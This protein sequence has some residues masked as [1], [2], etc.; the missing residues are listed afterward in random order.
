MNRLLLWGAMMGM[1]IGLSTGRGGEIEFV[2]QFALAPDRAAALKQLIPGT[3]DYYYWNSLHLLNT[4]QFE[5]V[6]ELLKPWV[7]RHGETPRVWEIRTRRAFLTYDQNPQAAL[8]YLRGRFGIQFPHRKEEL[9][10]EPNFPTTLDPAIVSRA[11]YQQ[12]ALARHGNSLNGF[13]DSA[14][15]WLIAT[16]LTPDQRRQLLSRLKRPDYPQLVELVAADLG[17]PNSGGFGS[18]EI[19]RLLLKSQLDE[20]LKLKPELLNQQ[21]FVRAYIVKLQHG[22]DVDWRYDPQLLKEYL[23]RLQAFADRLEPVHNS[24]KA[25]VLYHRLWLDRSRGVFDLN[26]LLAYLKLPRPTGYIAKVLQESEAFRQFP[27]DLNN[28]YD[29]VTLLPPIGNDEPL[30]RSYLAHFLLAGKPTKDFE[31]FINDVYLKHLFAETKIVNS[32]G[33]PEQWASLL[34]PDQFRRLKDRVDLDFDPANQ[35][36]FA[37]N[38][39]VRLDVHVK[40]VSTLIVKV[41]EINARNFYRIHAR[42]IDTDINLDGLVAND[43]QSHA[44][45]ESPFHRVTRHFEFPKLDRP[46][47]YVIDF[48]GNGQSSRALIRKGSLRH[49]VRTTAAGQAFTVLDDANAQV[50]NATLWTAGHEYAADDSGEILVPFSTNPSRQPVVL[51]AP[52]AGKPG[53]TYSALG[54]YQQEAETYQFNAGFYVDRESLLTRKTAELLI[55]PGLSVNGTPVSLKMLEDIKLTL[56]STDLDGISSSVEIPNFELFAD[57]ESIH[58]FLVPQ[59]LVSL[60]VRLSAKIRQIITGTKLDVAAADVFTLNGIRRTEKIEDL[61]LLRDAGNYV[62]ELRGLTGEPRTSRPVSLSFLHRDF[63][64]ALGVVLKTDPNGRIALGPLTDIASLTASGPEGTSHT[65]AL[66]GDKH[67]YPQTLN[68]QLGT[69]IS[70]PYLGTSQ[71]PLR[72]ELSLLE[73]VGGSYSVDRFEHLTLRDGLLIIDKLPAGD[74]DLLLKA[75][76]THITLHVTA[77]QHVGR[78]IVGSVRQLE[79]RPL[80]PL[81]IESI[82]PNDDKV[83]IQLRNMST[84]ARVHVFVTRYAPDYDA[85]GRLSRVRGVEPYVFR[86]TRASSSY[87]TGRNIGDEYRYI[88]DR[89]FATKFPGNMLERPSLLLNPWAVRETQTGAQTAVEG[90]FFGA[91]GEKSEADAQR[92]NA[93]A[94]D[95]IAVAEQFADLDFLANASAVLVNL[96]PDKD[97]VIEIERSAFEAQQ[98]ILVVAVDPLNTT[99]RRITL[100]EPKPLFVD[101]RLTNGLNPAGHFTRQKQV[102]L[103]AKGQEFLLDDITTA[104][105]EAFDSLSKVYGLYATLNQDPKLAEFA[106]LLTWPELSPEQKRTLYSQYASHELSFFLSQKDPDFYRTVIKPYLADKRDKTFLDH[107]LLEDDLSGYLQPWNFAQLNIAEQ[108][109]LA[110]RIEAER[111]SVKRHVADLFAVLPPDVERSMHLFD[112]AL[113]RGTMETGDALGLQE[114]LRS[115]EDRTKLLFD[116]K[117]GAAL[118]AAAPAPMA[119]NAVSELKRNANRRDEQLEKAK[120]DSKDRSAAS[121]E[122]RRSGADKTPDESNMPAKEE[123]RLGELYTDDFTDHRQSLRQLYR[124][125]DPTWEWAENNY[126]KLTIDQQIAT[127][128]TVNAFW[129]DFA[130]HDPATPF[131]SRH[132]AEASRNFPEMLLALAV[133]DLPFKQ[134]EHQTRF[135][136]SKMTFTPGGAAVIFHEEIEPAAAPPEASAVLVTQNFFRHGDRQRIENGE[137]VDKFV[138]EE[139]LRQTVYGCQIV[140]TNPTSARQ[141]L[142]L[143]LQIPQGSIPVL[144]SQATKTVYLTLEPYHTQ[145]V[146]F[147]FYFPTAGE[148]TQFPVHV[149]KREQLIAAAKPVVFHVVDQPTNLD[150]QS[151]DYVSQHGSLEDVVAFLNEHNIQRLNLDRIAWRMHDAK[152]FQT[153]IALLQQRH[154]YQQTLWSYALLHNDALVA[155]TYLQNVEP[156]VNEVGGRLNSVLLTVDPVA[157]R[158]YEHLEYKPLVN[159]RA[160]RLGPQRQIV[161]DRLLWQYHRFLKQ[162][163]YERTLDDEDQL[164]TTY[165]LLLQDRI[166][167]ALPMFAAVDRDRIAE[168]IQFDYCDAYLKFF[169]A[170]PEA[171]RPIAD[172]YADHPVDRWRNAFATIPAQLDEASGKVVAVIDPENRDQQ[173]GQLASTEPSFELSLDARQLKIAHRH[174]KSVQ[175]N[176]Y[177]MDLELLF[178]RNPFVQQFGDNFASIQPNRTITVELKPED[179]ATDVALPKE[180]LNRNVLVEVVG[181]GIT[182]TLPY[183]ANTLTVQIIENYGQ[184]QVTHAETRRPVPKAYVK[185][186]ART[187]TGEVKFYKDGYTDLRGRFDYASLSTNELDMAAKFSLLILSEEYGALVREA[188]PPRR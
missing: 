187:A 85:F 2:E 75:T 63:P 70:L 51:T 53:A 65:W 155:G 64:D 118:P 123:E 109:L 146:E 150:K 81:Q 112:T 34:P 18:F 104:K 113:R 119:G 102:S 11:K 183:Y 165:Y 125:L 4:E 32:L 135:D 58:E 117:P 20:L 101:L 114:A 13:G 162:L 30:V 95:T 164:A 124:K 176:F 157:R 182:R 144:N 76:G 128:I 67:T 74:F 21:A 54:H 27:C 41:F 80:P 107:Y 145:T 137:T 140:I 89:K 50:P 23:E 174:L 108:I 72:S 46:G 36:D 49:L 149:A 84:T 61:H 90:G 68:A 78:F 105:F 177:E 169:S 88:I 15:D 42:E 97:G 37:A 179:A 134:P 181:G 1:G 86:S 93:M 173:Q 100:P 180:L 82:T 168:K 35:T 44:Y 25:H 14:L 62:L 139:F 136:Q 115:V 126:H 138:T 172:R 77:G 171:A 175:V 24:L 40:N 5:K 188:T 147:H 158:T 29:G 38:D 129:K 48:I 151:W 166:E 154:V 7:L 186:Y 132:F 73:L 127:L 16:E 92:K 87:L 69:A 98:E 12:Q 106:F 28:N 55:R 160:H 79:T 31:P 47:I 91:A 178:S 121:R 120:Q 8:D 83:R 185:V 152:A 131:L 39:P 52:V 170:E 159:A 130:A 161:N 122:R 57:R 111:P 116:G 56:T 153:I 59:R 103:V 133:L 3:E 66:T 9:N 60:Q 10:A 19:H 94:G 6:E 156:I 99:A 141:K 143:L 110:R 22:P 43:E 71:E 17:H 96:V 148:F 26:R 184:V 33:E 167:E 163:A 45:E 142:S